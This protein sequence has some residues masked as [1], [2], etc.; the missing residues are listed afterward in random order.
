MFLLL[1]IFL[2]LGNRFTLSPSTNFVVIAA[3]VIEKDELERWSR[4]RLLSSSS[5][6]PYHRQQHYYSHDKRVE[7]DMLT[8]DNRDSLHI[9]RV[10]EA[11]LWSRYYSTSYP[12]TKACDFTLDSIRSCTS[13]ED[14]ATTSPFK[15]QNGT[16]FHCNNYADSIAEISNAACI[17]NMTLIYS[18]KNIGSST[19]VQS[20]AASIHGSKPWDILTNFNSSKGGDWIATGDS[21]FVPHTQVVNIC[22]FFTRPIDVQVQVFCSNHAASPI[23]N[24]SLAI[25]PSSPT[26]TCG[27]T[28][29]L[30]CSNGNG[31]SDCIRSNLDNILSWNITNGYE[32]PVLLDTMTIFVAHDI[33]IYIPFHSTALH[34]YQTTT[35]STTQYSTMYGDE[36]VAV[37]EYRT[38]PIWNRITCTVQA[39]WNS[40][41]I[42]VVTTRNPSL[43]PRSIHPMISPK[44]SIKEKVSKNP[45]CFYKK[46]LNMK[47]KSKGK[48]DMTSPSPKMPWKCPS[49]KSKKKSYA[50]VP[51]VYLSI[52]PSTN[53]SFIKGMK[54]SSPFGSIRPTTVKKSSVKSTKSKSK[55]KTPISSTP[56][57][58]PRESTFKGTKAKSPSKSMHT[59]SF[60]TSKDRS[61]LKGMKSTSPST[62]SFKGTQ[63]QSPS[64]SMHTS[65]FKLSS[66][67]SK[68][69]QAKI[70]ILSS[71]K[72]S[73]DQSSLKRL[74]SISPVALSR[75]PTTMSSKRVKDSVLKSLKGVKDTILKSLKGV[76]D[77]NYK[78]SKSKKAIGSMN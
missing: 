33:P 32:V 48:I 27:C 53:G 28:L 7:E 58:S 59:R 40:S 34:K 78:K 61:S 56:R 76:K 1:V 37:L 41:P 3:Q 9:L 23:Q 13:H 75:S 21:I 46:Y 24:E 70:P 66:I 19:K 29:N 73:K 77:S 43:V 51:P 17:V 4:T 26:P 12:L 57:P 68:K 55:L 49:T 39:T 60:K 47:K 38:L 52:K 2:F 62:T 16:S 71:F 11:I 72:S 22:D 63:S 8:S 15:N 36:I 44:K 45:D 50:K 54:S 30:S 74:K 20:I 14:T 5:N 18:L 25:L 10:E 35:G 65:S 42:H 67:K 31:S 64:K 6:F 69:S